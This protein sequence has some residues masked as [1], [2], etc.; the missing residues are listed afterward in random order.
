MGLISYSL[1][2]WHASLQDDWDAYWEAHLG[3]HPI[4]AR[5]AAY[6]VLVAIVG[7]LSYLIIEHPFLRARQRSVLL[8]HSLD[9]PAGKQAGVVGALPSQQIALI[10]DV[11]DIRRL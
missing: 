3:G 1:Y 6:L 5:I 11:E 2:V 4:A 10:P 7:A 8:A 9:I